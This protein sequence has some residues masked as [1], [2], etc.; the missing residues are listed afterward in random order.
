LRFE[1]FHFFG[2]F[3]IDF[4]IDNNQ[5]SDDILNDLSPIGEIVLGFTFRTLKFLV[6]RVSDQRFTEIDFK[7]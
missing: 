3:S 1:T 4:S 7:T 2:T 6:R 5:V